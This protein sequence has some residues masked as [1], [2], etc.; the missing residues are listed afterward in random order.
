MN[1]YTVSVSA[2]EAAI[3]DAA[4]A[5]YPQGANYTEV[6]TDAQYLR[7]QAAQVIRQGKGKLA[8]FRE[9]VNWLLAVLPTTLR[10]NK[11]D[12]GFSLKK[13]LYEACLGKTPW[14]QPFLLAASRRFGG[15]GW[16]DKSRGRQENG[17]TGF[18]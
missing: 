6:N 17:M 13:K 18:L 8:L 2:E 1:S 7:N 12:A 15:R 16:R 10:A 14:F 3:I 9:D 11:R 5:Q 4:L